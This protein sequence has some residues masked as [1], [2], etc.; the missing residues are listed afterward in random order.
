MD[1]NDKLISLGTYIQILV[2]V[3]TET[4]NGC[5]YFYRVILRKL[6]NNTFRSRRMAHY[7]PFA[8]YSSKAIDFLRNNCIEVLPKICRFFVPVQHL[9]DY[10]FV[11]QIWFLR[12]IGQSF[13]KGSE[14][15]TVPREK[16][17]KS[18]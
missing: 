16:T 18:K 3:K 8:Q 14:K 7:L 10:H 15:N 11:V 2:Q 17:T 4:I 9:V 5:S 12:N 13:R 6:E 1:D